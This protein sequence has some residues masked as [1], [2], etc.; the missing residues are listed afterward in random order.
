M[1]PTD[2]LPAEKLAFIAHN[3]GLYESVQK[4]GGLFTSGKIANSTDINK[5][6]E[7]LRDSS[8][9]YD[10]DMIA[11]IINA[12]LDYSKHLAIR[13]VTLRDTSTKSIWRFATLGTWTKDMG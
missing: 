3:I 11:S 8:A 9:F 6:A 7:L 12:M 5:I 2:I 1:E 10:A 4:F 13:K